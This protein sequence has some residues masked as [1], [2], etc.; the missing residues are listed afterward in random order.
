MKNT[1]KALMAAGA[2]ALGTTLAA[3]TLMAQPVAQQHPN[4]AYAAA[5]A[6]GLLAFAMRKRRRTAAAAL[7]GF[8]VVA[9]YEGYK[10][11]GLPGVG[12]AHASP[13]TSSSTPKPFPSSTP[14]SSGSSGS[15]SLPSST[16]ASSPFWKGSAIREGSPPP[17][18]YSNAPIGA[19]NPW[20]WPSDEAPSLEL[21]QTDPGPPLDEGSPSGWLGQVADWATAPGGLAN[22]LTGFFTDDSDDSDDSE[23]AG[24]VLSSIGRRRSRRR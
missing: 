5:A 4:A 15:M 8:A 12:T 14:T 10:R 2:G 11:V 1:T 19:M 9:A 22:T 18:D 13:A 24:L 3:D 17:L 21:S 23:D 20:N 7:G 6:A 16:S